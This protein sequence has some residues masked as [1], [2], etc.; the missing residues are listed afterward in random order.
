M[1]SYVLY[2]VIRVI[3]SFVS[4]RVMGSPVPASLLVLT[5]LHC[6]VTMAMNL[7]GRDVGDLP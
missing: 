2:I 6:D 1:K 3:Y 7:G 5:I 4:G